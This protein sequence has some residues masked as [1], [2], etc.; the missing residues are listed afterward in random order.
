MCMWGARRGRDARHCY[1]CLVCV[2][3]ILARGGLSE[4]NATEL[5]GQR[6]SG[7][8]VYMIG[9]SAFRQQF[10][11]ICKAAKAPVQTKVATLKK[12]ARVTLRSC[13]AGTT[14][15]AFMGYHEYGWHT[16]GAVGNLAAATG[17]SPTVVYFTGGPH[18][19]H[20]GNERPW[21]L[22]DVWKGAE[23]K[24][25]AFV[26]TVHRQHPGAAVILH[27]A[28]SICEAKL[29]SDLYLA[30]VAQLAK[31]PEPIYLQCEKWLGGHYRALPSAGFRDDCANGL[32]TRSGSGKLQARVAQ[33]FSRYL[34]EDPDRH[35]LV[36]GFAI[37][38][39]R[40]QET[41]DGLHYPKLLAKEIAGL[42]Q[43]I[44]RIADARRSGNQSAAFMAVKNGSDVLTGLLGG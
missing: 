29:T 43:E 42:R 37:T 27:L 13:S 35:G 16:P 6:P 15:Y 40:C 32:F 2:G 10:F 28:H 1:L 41:S 38:D 24:V 44:A 22:Y 34:R 33:T 23:E 25:G 18:F 3:A 36:D 39:G 4:A 26:E 14:G 7:E 8:N 12:G 20:L 21:E 9:D 17:L 31:A 11:E 19:L 30:A 5:A